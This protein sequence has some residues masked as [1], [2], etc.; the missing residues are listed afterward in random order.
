[1][2][3]DDIITILR[4]DLQALSDILGDKKFLLG[5]RPTTCDFTAFGHLAV[6]YYLPFRQPVTDLLDDEFPNLKQLIER[7]RLHYW[8]DWKRPNDK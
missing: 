5:I 8:S 6:T 1:M 4:K 3:R 7:M 2:K